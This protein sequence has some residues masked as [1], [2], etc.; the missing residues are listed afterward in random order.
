MLMFYCLLLELSVFN[1]MLLLLY[2]KRDS[3]SPSPLHG[4]LYILCYK[5]DMFF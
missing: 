5:C 1:F 4:S 2:Y 3:P